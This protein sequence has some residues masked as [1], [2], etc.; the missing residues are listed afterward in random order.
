MDSRPLPL[1]NI[2]IHRALG[3]GGLRSQPRAPRRR[4]S[5]P[6][7]RAQRPAPR[8]GA[9]RARTSASRHLRTAAAP[10][11]PRSAPRGSRRGRSGAPLSSRVCIAAG[12]TCQPSQSMFPAPFNF[13]CARISATSAPRS[14][15][16][17]PVTR[18][19][20]S[21]GAACDVMPAARAGRPPPPHTHTP[22]AAPGQRARSRRYRPCHTREMQSERRPLGRRSRPRARAR[23]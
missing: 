8:P 1:R 20:R 6:R 14:S 5:R 23:A 2:C 16:G 12:T 15:S 13:T 7:A 3:G 19:T 22:S 9:P 10:S 11:G 21:C 17:C 4:P 18:R